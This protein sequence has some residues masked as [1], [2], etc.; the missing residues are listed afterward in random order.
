ML[1]WD[2]I[3]DQIRNK[4]PTDSSHEI[5]TMLAHVFQTYGCVYQMM[6]ARMQHTV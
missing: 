1:L 4:H 6:I 3:D 5:I 2:G